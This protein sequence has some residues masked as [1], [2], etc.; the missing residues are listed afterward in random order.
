[1][2]ASQFLGRDDP[3][4]IAWM[5]QERAKKRH[6]GDLMLGKSHTTTEP[7]ADAAVGERMREAAITE[8]AAS[9]LRQ[10]EFMR[11]LDKIPEGRHGEVVLT[12]SKKEEEKKQ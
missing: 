1:M 9:F 7:R 11:E 2:S 4:T 3:R 5:E 12:R 6:W 8:K 10:P